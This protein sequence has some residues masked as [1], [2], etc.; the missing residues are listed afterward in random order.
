M[1]ASIEGGLRWGGKKIQEVINS[2]IER[3]LY[4]T[5]EIVVEAA[6]R[7]APVDTGAL[8]ESIDYI[9]I[10]G[11]DDDRSELRI[12]IGMFYGIFQEFGT[13]NIPPHPFIRPALLEA[14]RVWGF[15]LNVNFAPVTSGTWHGLYAMTGKAHPRAMMVG[16][17]RT[18]GLTMRQRHHVE[19]RL[20]PSIKQWHRGNVKRARFTVAP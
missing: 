20:I 5:G 19:R 2:L 4:E 12:T 16:P 6:R 14:K 18:Q 10:Y 1:F 9:V 7:L 17:S 11:E 3:K 13:R 8:R 15:D